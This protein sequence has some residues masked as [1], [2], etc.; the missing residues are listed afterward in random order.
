VSPSKLAPLAL[1]AA[2]GCAPQFLTYVAREAVPVA[3]VE[4]EG[5]ITGDVHD[6]QGRPLEGALVI[7]MATALPKEREITTD[8]EGRFRFDELPPG[9]YTIQVLYERGDVS[10]IV[11]IGSGGGWHI[12]YIVDP[13]PRF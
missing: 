10:E 9:N 1:I 5:V 6:P 11:D 12:H 8:A 13:D 4:M 7:A 2:V 3:G